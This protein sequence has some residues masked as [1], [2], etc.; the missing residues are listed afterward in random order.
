LHACVFGTF[1]TLYISRP[2]TFGPRRQTNIEMQVDLSTWDEMQLRCP[3]VSLLI[4]RFHCM[5]GMRFARELTL[6]VVNTLHLLGVS[7]PPIIK[8]GFVTAKE[9]N[10]HQMQGITWLSHTT[11]TMVIRYKG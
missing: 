9:Y 10:C 4:W 11:G 5:K 8:L 3:K 1:E 7:C 6:I 2:E